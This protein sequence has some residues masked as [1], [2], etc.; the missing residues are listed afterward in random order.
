MKL[1]PTSRLRH[2][3]GFSR[4][5]ADNIKRKIL[6]EGIWTRPLRVERN[7]WLVLD[8]QHRMEI[9]LDLGLRRVPCQ[10]YDY[11]DVEVWSLRDKHEVSRERVIAKALAGD[12]YPYKPAKHRFPDEVGELAIPL[13]ELLAKD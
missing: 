13:A 2:I 3:E 6:E 8:G 5:R 10:L 1:I 11:A 12:I 9:A 4:K 7:H